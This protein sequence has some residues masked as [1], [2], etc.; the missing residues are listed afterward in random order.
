MI[1]ELPLQPQRCLELDQAE[2]VDVQGGPAVSGAWPV[3]IKGC[4]TIPHASGPPRAKTPWRNK[5]SAGEG[6]QWQPFLP[7][8]RSLTMLCQILRQ[9]PLHFISRAAAAARGKPKGTRGLRLA[10]ERGGG[11]RPR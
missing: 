1:D 10:A 9:K 7:G 6:C 2:Q 5:A 4:H 11:Y 8:A 3:T